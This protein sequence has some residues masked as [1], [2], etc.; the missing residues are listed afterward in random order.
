MTI[1]KSKKINL[2]LAILFAIS[3]LMLWLTGSFEKKPELKILHF[4]PIVF[5][6]A[7][8]LNGVFNNKCPN[9][10]KFRRKHPGKFCKF[11]GKEFDFNKEY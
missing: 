9:C 6:L 5:F 1:N 8:I 2:V 7:A 4:I 11:C 3:I 10:K